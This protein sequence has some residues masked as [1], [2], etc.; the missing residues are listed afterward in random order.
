MA[1]VLIAVVD[2]TLSIWRHSR[3]RTGGH[4]LG[5]F[6][7]ALWSLS[8]FEAPATTIRAIPLPNLFGD[9]FSPILILLVPW[10]W[11]CDSAVVPLIAQSML[12]AGLVPL[13]FLLARHLGNPPWPAVVLGIALGIHPGFTAAALVEFHEVAFA[14]ALLLAVVMFAERGQWRWYWVALAAFIVV[15]E[16]M[17]LYAALFGVTLILHRRWKIGVATV[18]VGVGYFLFVTSFVIPA[19]AGQEYI[20][21]RLYPDLG[22][23]QLGILEHVLHHPVNSVVLLVSTPEKRRTINLML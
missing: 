6:D 11:V 8:R 4:D 14:P 15:K 1:T 21:W 2:S 22:G 7:Q 18:G 3:F 5:I 16:S 9:H 10:Y 17:A 19:L 23:S 20:Y 12:L 13:G